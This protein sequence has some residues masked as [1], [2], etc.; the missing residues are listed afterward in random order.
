MSIPTPKL[1]PPLLM[2]LQLML[3]LQLIPIQAGWSQNARSKAP[4]GTVI[5]W[6]IRYNNPD[7]GINAWPNRKGKVIAFLKEVHPQV[8]CLQEVLSGQL[9]DLASALPDYSRVGAGRD[10]GKEAG[11]YVPVFY[12]TD[13]FRLI[14]GSH[15]WLSETPDK[16]GRL[17]WDAA[18]T[19][20]VTWISLIDK[21]GGDTLFVFNTH[22]DH[23]GVKARLMSAKQLTEAVDSLAGNHAVIITGDFNSSTDDSPYQVIT[24]AGFHDSRIVSKI[25]PAGPEYTFTGFDKSQAPGERIDFIFVRNTQPVQSYFVRDHGPDGVYLSDHLPVI[26]GF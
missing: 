21:T 8:I 13:N 12:R 2:K 9:K 19:R 5:C 11:E 17:G 4:G 24:G 16:P 10:D 18:C 23:I 20:M 7:D 14:K 1:Q 6:N 15:F 22:F 26:V 3:L 25:A